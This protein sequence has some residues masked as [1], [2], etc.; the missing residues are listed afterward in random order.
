MRSNSGTYD[1]MTGG[2]TKLNTNEMGDLI[3]TK[4]LSQ[5]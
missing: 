1:I 4:V 3:A 5:S 2:M